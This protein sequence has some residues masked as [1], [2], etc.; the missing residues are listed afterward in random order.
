MITVKLIGGLGNQMFQLAFAK[1]LSLMLGQELQVDASVY[2]QY[3]I[4]PFSANRLHILDG[5]NIIHSNED[6]SYKHRISQRFYHIYQKVLKSVCKI[7]NHGFPLF[8]FLSKYGLIYNFD[9]F[10]YK[11]N[12]EDLISVNDISI[13]G[14]FQSENYFYDNKDLIKKMLKVK[15]EPTRKELCSI[16]EISNPQ[17]VA[18]S[19]RLGDDYAQSGHLKVCDAEYFINSIRYMKKKLVNPIFFI[20]SDDIDR[21]KKILGTNNNYQFM[22]GFE[23]YQSLR[24]M[25]SASNFI[26]SNSSFS[27]WGAYLSESRD[28]IIISP[29]KWFNGMQKEPAIFLKSMKKI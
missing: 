10:F 20:F 9:R 22:C 27:W 24:L 8:V 23:D 4:R 2:S 15:F 5:V 26:I 18:V 28:K 12:Y 25:Y 16:K 29:K 21:A 11:L 6:I 13:Y 1:H 14:Y 7:E 3:K 17:S 19:M